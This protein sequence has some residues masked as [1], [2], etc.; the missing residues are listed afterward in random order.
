MASSVHAALRVRLSYC[1]VQRDH[2]HAGGNGAT[3][4]GLE[5]LLARSTVLEKKQRVTASPAGPAWGLMSWELAR[6]PS[7]GASHSSWQSQTAYKN[8]IFP[9]VSGS[10]FIDC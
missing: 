10:L 4:G 9:S 3:V 7:H 5:R 2:P 1:Q 6:P 8:M